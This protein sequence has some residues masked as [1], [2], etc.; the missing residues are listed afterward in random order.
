M[1]N[2]F[3][4]LCSLIGKRENYTIL[5]EQLS[6]ISFYSLIPNDDN[7]GVDGVQLRDQY[8]EEEGP[9]ALSLCPTGPCSVLEMMIGLSYR[10]VFESAESKWEKNVGQWFWILVDNLGLTDYA[11]GT[12]YEPDLRD[13]IVAIVTVLLERR[14][15]SDGNGGLFP[16][17]NPKKDQKNVEIW[18]QMSAYILE[19]YPI[20]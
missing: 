18:Y 20:F 10:L 8:L 13:T 11:N 5:L 6:Y 7:R 3:D 17:K 19:N 2:Y 15:K 16:L 9:H 14:Y 12:M 1:N 4:Y